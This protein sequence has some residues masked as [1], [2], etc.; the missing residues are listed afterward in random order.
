MSGAPYG[1]QR[2]ASL[3]ELVVGMA[4]MSI[5]LFAFYSVVERT[6]ALQ[7]ETGVQAAAHAEAERAMN[8]IAADLRKASGSS[9]QS[10]GHSLTLRQYTQ[11]GTDPESGQEPE[12]VLDQVEVHYGL[13]ATGEGL[14]RT[15]G[16]LVQLVGPKITAFETSVTGQALVQIRLTATS[17]A[18][19]LGTF[20]A[21]RESSFA[22][23]VP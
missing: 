2:G 8:M 16:D 9:L 6:N 15:Q 19:D 12:L 21:T 23:L 3:V 22:V 5:V 7:R 1:P 17:S 14:V 20:T 13:A 11:I 10:D 18:A 4:I